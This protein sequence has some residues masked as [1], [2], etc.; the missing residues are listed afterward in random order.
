[1]IIRA[2]PKRL[3]RAYPAFSIADKKK[4]SI[5]D[6]LFPKKQEQ[7]LQTSFESTERL[8]ELNRRVEMFRAVPEDKWAK[9]HSVDT[10]YT[11]FAISERQRANY[12]AMLYLF[13]CVVGC[14]AV[15]VSTNLLGIGVASALPHVANFFTVFSLLC[16]G[17]AYKSLDYMRK[18][19]LVKVTY[20]TKKQMLCFTKVVNARDLKDTWVHPQDIGVCFDPKPRQNW[21]YY[22]KVTG[23]KYPTIGTGEW[24]NEELFLYSLLRINNY[25][26]KKKLDDVK[27]VEGKADQKLLESTFKPAPMA[28]P[29]NRK[30]IR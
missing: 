16:A 21:I 27:R 14:T 12:S 15:I 7:S 2:F 6:T 13:R 19:M 10:Q 20:D 18:K 17:F 25:L 30:L 24:V 9:I 28:K 3:L 8:E 23:E 11:I 4:G 5:F 26:P 1:M 22:N 29:I